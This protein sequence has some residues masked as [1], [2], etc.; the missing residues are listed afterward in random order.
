MTSLNIDLQQFSLARMA[1]LWRGEGMLHW[2]IFQPRYPPLAVEVGEDCLHL[3]HLPRSF[4]G[5]RTETRGLYSFLDVD[6]CTK[7]LD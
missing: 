3:A 5:V 1:S 4:R 6:Y 2:K 7:F